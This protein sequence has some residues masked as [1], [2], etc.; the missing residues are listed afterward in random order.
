M[1]DNKIAALARHHSN[2]A[3]NEDIQRIPAATVILLR[4]STPGMEILM[5]RKTSNVT[6]GGMWVFPGGRIDDRDGA[7]DDPMER[8]ARIAAAREAQEEAALQ[9]AEQDMCWFSH[10][11]PPEV[12]KR[13][14][15]TWFY[16][17]RA[18]RQT[19]TIDNGEIK[20][21]R[22]LTAGAALRKQAEGEIELAPPTFVTLRNLSGYHSVNEALSAIRQAQPRHYATRLCASGDDLV[23]LWSGDAGYESGE[24]DTEGPRHRLSMKTGGWIFEDAGWRSAEH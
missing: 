2:N 6:F 11:T 20:E 21:S 7:A 8:R 14:F 10:W 1:P 12:G 22:W 9:V 18:P 4:D 23:L 24:A 3:D 15:I 16:A 5:L 19:V 13:R 17:A